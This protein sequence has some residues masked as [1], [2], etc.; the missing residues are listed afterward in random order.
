[1]SFS[2]EPFG[3][4]SRD[5]AAPEPVAPPPPEPEPIVEPVQ[6]LSPIPARGLAVLTCMDCRID[7]LDDFGLDL[8]D[9]V[10]LRNA[11]ASA[12]DD[13]VR[14]LRLAVENLGVTAV[15]VI[16]HTDC[17]AFGSDDAASAEGADRAAERIGALL[18]GVD[19]RSVVFDVRTGAISG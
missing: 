4:T 19:V 12:S 15:R 11:G 13:V 2:W 18:P 8:G 9:A 17:A 10:V 5:A 3:R 14:S 6:E 16:G 7:P 1:L